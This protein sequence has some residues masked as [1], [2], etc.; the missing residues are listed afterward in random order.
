MEC[1]QF[2]KKYGKIIII[3]LII[4]LLFVCKFTFCD[5]NKV[6]PLS[7]PMNQCKQKIVVFDLDETLGHFVELGMFCDCLKQLNP[8]KLDNEHCF[9]IFDLFPEFLRPNII[10]ILNYIKIKKYENKCN[11]V[12]I[13]TNNQGPQKWARMI[14]EY[15]E[16]KINDPLF[17]QIIAAFR[18]NGKRVEMGRTSHEK[19]F[20]DLI[21]CTK[22]PNDTQIFFLDDQ[23]HPFMDHEKVFYINV[24]PY[25]HT[26][27]FDEM[28]KRYM[29]SDIAQG[30]ENK[31]VFSRDMKLLLEKYKFKDEDKSSMEE[32]VDSIISKKIIYYLEEFFMNKMRNQTRRKRRNRSK[33]T[34]KR[35][36]K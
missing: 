11:K 24:K 26:L 32:K 12:M 5:K 29:E 17:D 8:H 23:Y 9:K 16:N 27:S 18:V 4:L 25:I 36:K 31:E 28:I 7:M 3:V 35:K 2:I 1:T 33:K 22:L 21:R 15:F 14:K 10:E 30:I 19:S 6:S 13:Y 20:D 34:L